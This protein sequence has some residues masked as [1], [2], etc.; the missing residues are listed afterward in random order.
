MPLFSTMG[1][2]RITS[3]MNLLKRYWPMA[4]VLGATREHRVVLVHGLIPLSAYTAV[5]SKCTAN[6][7]RRI[8]H[9]V[10][11]LHA[12]VR[13]V[14]LGNWPRYAWNMFLRQLFLQLCLRM[15]IC[16][17]RGCVWRV[18]KNFVRESNAAN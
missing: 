3:L 18:F 7:L 17:R 11:V 4:F 6:G 5:Y 12:L 10:P 14:P 8:L 13:T 15:P 16:R 9:V 2:T 1:A